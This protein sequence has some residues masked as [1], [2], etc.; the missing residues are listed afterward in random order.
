MNS[1]FIKLSPG[2]EGAIGDLQIDPKYIPDGEGK[3]IDMLIV[4]LTREVE[5]NNVI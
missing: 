3:P 2:L 1:R 4:D 5:E